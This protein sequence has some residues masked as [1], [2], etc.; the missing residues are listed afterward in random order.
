MLV[1]TDGGADDSQALG[2]CAVLDLSSVGPAARASRWLADYGAEVVKVGPVPRHG[3][4]QIVPPAYAYSGHR[5]MKR[6][7]FDLKADHGRD[8][9]LR[10]ATGADVV[11]ES[12]RPGTVDR[13]G[14]GDADVRAVNPAIVYC[15]TSGYGQHGPAAGRAGHDL[16]Y[17]AAGGYLDCTG[18]D[19]AGRPPIPG[20]TIADSAGGGMHAVMSIL[21]ALRRDRWPATSG[22][23][24]YL[25]VSAADGVLSFMSLYVDEYLATGEVPGPGH[26]VLTGRYACYDLYRTAD[27]RWLAVAAIE[28]HFWANLC[29]ALGVE[30]WI[31]HQT[32]DDVQ[33]EVRADVARALASKD[34]DT[35][36]AE[37]ADTDT[38]VAPVLSV[39]ELVD[40]EQYVA[41]GAFVEAKHPTE[42]TFRQVAPMLAGQVRPTGTVEIP[43]ATATDTAELSGGRGLR[44]GR[45]RPPGGE[46]GGRV[47]GSDVD[48]D[49][50]P[51]DVVALIDVVQYEEEGEFPVERGYVWTSAS[52]VENGNPLF[53]DDEVADELTDGPIAMPTMLS[54]W[55]RP[56]HWEPG[57]SGSRPSRSR[58]TS[59]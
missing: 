22:G 50:L 38:C 47:S 59:T 2:V 51:D 28:P 24:A 57:A 16:D 14:I 41:R 29:R 32:D 37:L 36:V 15:S 26:N 49:A 42:G 4:V 3:G 27:D 39:P 21:A 43:D 58:C 18:R 56:H 44:A 6:A 23:E 31:E 40:D 9:F 52:S 1:P 33:D 55:F 12:F 8:A 25:D 48:A 13:L 35:W 20:A 46:R 7:L 30:R 45:G 10:L 19:G 54:V 5:G 53:W 11:I 17:L 34:R